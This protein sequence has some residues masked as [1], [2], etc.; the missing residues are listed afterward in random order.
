MS[1]YLK[2]DIRAGA[3]IVFC[4]G[5]LAALVF[6]IGGFKKFETSYKIRLLTDSAYGVAQSSVVTYSGVKVG[7]VKQLRI[8]SDDEIKKV[9]KDFGTSDW[10]V[11]DLRVEMILQVSSNVVLRQDSKAQIVGSGL[12]GDQTVNLTPGTPTKS[13]I[14]KGVPLF[15]VE[16]TGLG[17]LQEGIGE[18]NFDVLIPNV[19]KIVMNL[20]EASDRIKA[21]TTKVDEL[22]GD[23]DRKNQISSM[24][25]KMEHTLDE[26]D[27]VIT[28]SSDDIRAAAAN[29]NEATTMLKTE[30]GPILTSL[31]T[32]ANSVEGL[33][34]NNKEEINEIVDE[35]KETAVNFNQFSKKV[36]KYPWTLIRKTKVDKKDKVLFPQSASIQVDQSKP[37]EEKREKVF[38]FF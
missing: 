36:K 4:I 16:L 33:L 14:D 15:D 18:I 22:L 26:I 19:R 11:D 1:D 29:F 23:L 7:E 10:G 2:S 13:K 31:K 3:V 17:K 32:S 21:T 37:K 35:F 6:Y 34:S 9:L 20:T 5:L 27:S 12:V 30:L 28:D 38:F 24:L 25:D 8:L